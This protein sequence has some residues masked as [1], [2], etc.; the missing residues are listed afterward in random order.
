MEIEEFVYHVSIISIVKYVIVQSG[1]RRGGERGGS[2]VLFCYQWQAALL[3]MLACPNMRYPKKAPNPTA[4]MIHPLYVMK[5]SLVLHS[6]QPGFEFHLSRAG[7]SGWGARVGLN[8]WG[9][10]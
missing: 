3:S 6:C 7:Q 4:S 10:C 8:I 1:D 2:V 9:F 5:R